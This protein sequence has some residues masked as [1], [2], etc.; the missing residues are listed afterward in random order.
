MGSLPALTQPRNTTQESPST[1]ALVA[2]PNKLHTTHIAMPPIAMGTPIQEAAAAKLLP[3]SQPPQSEY[4]NTLGMPQGLCERFVES[5]N[6]F[7]LRIW[8]ID[9]SGSMAM[10]DGHRIV[11][12]GAGSCATIGCSRWEELCDTI[13]FHGKL[14]AHLGAPT[15]FRLLKVGGGDSLA[16]AEAEC[17][18]I[19]QLTSTSPT[20]RTPLCEQIRQVIEHIKSIAPQLRAV[21]QRCVLVIAS[22]GAAT[23]GDIAAAMKPLEDL[24]V[25]VVIRLCTDDD[26]VSVLGVARKACHA[27]AVLP[28]AC[29]RAVCTACHGTSALHGARFGGRA[30]PR[31]YGEA[32]CNLDAWQAAHCM[33]VGGAS[34]RQG[35]VLPEDGFQ[36]TAPLSNAT[37]RVVLELRGRDT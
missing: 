23:D 33:P 10:G 24:P 2:L 15:E 1:R 26:A 14:A 7:P 28:C 37:G 8:I 6:T 36:E 17:A 19:K 29:A 20:G 34:T 35:R 9:N 22:D 16:K 13:S 30:P 3:N 32:G 21:N 31:L 5:R 11:S 12:H 4:L 27:Q 18:Q 25:W